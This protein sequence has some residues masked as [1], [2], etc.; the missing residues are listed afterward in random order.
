MFTSASARQGVSEDR[1]HPSK[2][3]P[4]S[5]TWTEFES[6]SNNNYPTA[7]SS[8]T[9]STLGTTTAVAADSRNSLFCSNTSVATSAIN[10]ITMVNNMA[11]HGV[12]E[13]DA[14]DNQAKDNIVKV[15]NVINSRQTTNVDALFDPGLHL[16][17]VSNEPNLSISVMSSAAEDDTRT[18][19][20]EGPSVI[21]GTSRTSG[22]SG[23]SGTSRKSKSVKG[24]TTNSKSE[25]TRSHD[26][27]PGLFN[28]TS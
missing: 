5:S 4:H 3:T 9:I 1:E 25:S 6:T 12:I 13:K 22:T 16:L 27:P 7:L 24:W 18:Y 10:N 15:K 19:L 17:G 14:I 20:L 2:M 21:S 26:S 28:L 11:D 8:V 23:T